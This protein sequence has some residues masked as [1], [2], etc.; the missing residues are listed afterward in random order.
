MRNYS[1][2]QTITSTYSCKDTTAPPKSAAKKNLAEKPNK[3][4]NK[5]YKRPIS[6]IQDMF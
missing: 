6:K 2:G 1:G 4:S 3:N 5:S